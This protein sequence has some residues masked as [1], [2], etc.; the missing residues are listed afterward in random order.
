M[1]C[2]AKVGWGK[3]KEPQK[4]KNRKRLSFFCLNYSPFL[5]SFVSPFTETQVAVE[6]TQ[7]TSSET[8]AVT[9]ATG[10]QQPTGSSQGR[11]TTS[12]V[13]RSTIS[14]TQLTSNAPQSSSTPSPTSV[15][16]TNIGQVREPRLGETGTP[17]KAS[18]PFPSQSPWWGCEE[19]V[20]FT[21]CLWLCWTRP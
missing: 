19:P 4:T 14:S 3:T 17:G 9:V 5:I 18:L 21:H 12:L 10:V 15:I 20:S 11:G 7:H 6:G 8:P 2:K 13:R 16:P 1:V